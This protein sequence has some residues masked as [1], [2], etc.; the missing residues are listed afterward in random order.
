[1]ATGGQDLAIYLYSNEYVEAMLSAWNAR[2]PLNVNYRYVAEEPRTCSRIR[3]RR[4]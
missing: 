4:R 3:A 1:M 2:G